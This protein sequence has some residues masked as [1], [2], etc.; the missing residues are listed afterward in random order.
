M[1]YDHF[2]TSRLNCLSR[3]NQASSSF[4]Q[5]LFEHSTILTHS[6]HIVSLSDYQITQFKF[7]LKSCHQVDSLSCHTQSQHI[8]L[9][10]AYQFYHT[11]QNL[12]G[13]PFGTFNYAIMLYYFSCFYT[14]NPNTCWFNRI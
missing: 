7:Q 2:L 5:K 3:T 4:A 8:Q 14:Y 9:V 6:W 12:D 10:L 1:A 13:Y 11:S